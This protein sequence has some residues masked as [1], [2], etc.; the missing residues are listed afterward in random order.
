MLQ[1]LIFQPLYNLLAF[2]SSLLH[3]ELGWAVLILAGLIRLAIWPWYKKAMADQ[4]K[5]AQLQPKIQ[6]IQKKYK[7]D[8]MKANQEV[9]NLFRTEK[10]N[11]GSSFLFLFFQIGVFLILF[12]FFK[13]AITNDWSPFLYSFIELPSQ[14]NYIFLGFIDTRAPS[15][16]LAIVSV[17]LNLVLVSVQ[18]STGQNKWLALGLP[19]VILLL[20]QNFPAIIILYWIGFSLVNVL[21]EFLINRRRKL[22]PIPVGDLK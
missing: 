21:Q 8:P 1:L 17:L 13:Q 2:F 5:M 10:I 7:Q 16:I 12:A 4:R 14:I 15:L 3:G 11:I 9:M 18:P 22:E 19:F 6:E 20:Y